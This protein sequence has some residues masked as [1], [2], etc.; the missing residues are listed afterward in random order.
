MR[1]RTD[2]PFIRNEQTPLLYPACSEGRPRG[3]RR[4]AQNIPCRPDIGATGPGGL[5]PPFE[6]IGVR[7][8]PVALRASPSADGRVPA[9]GLL[10]LVEG[11]HEPVEPVD[12][13]LVPRPQADQFG[14]KDG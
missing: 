6:R 14:S 9:F 10:E 12:V 4:Y 5:M 2:D 7:K 3:R 13:D 11:G 8:R 1:G